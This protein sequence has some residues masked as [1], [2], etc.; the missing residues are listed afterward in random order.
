MLAGGEP[1]DSCGHQRR[2]G[3][4]RCVDV[5]IEF[6]SPAATVAHAAL[7]AA[8][9]T[10]HVIGTTGLD[11]VE[12]Q[13]I[14]AAAARTAILRA[15]NMSLGVNLLLGLAEQVARA[16]PSGGVRRRDPRD[17]PQAQGRCA[18]RHGAGARRGGRA[19]PGRRSR[20]DLPSAAATVMTGAR[21][22]GAIG[23]AALRG[24]DAVGDHT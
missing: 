20:G 18:V 17:A 15:A 23:F 16:L 9:G 14:R 2:A 1:L 6:S 11:A 7:A 13:S 21:R 24:G 22:P 8:H 12:E 3:A 5:V 10:G 4:D 19:W